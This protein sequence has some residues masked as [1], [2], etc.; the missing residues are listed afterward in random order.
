MASVCPRRPH[1]GKCGLTTLCW[2]KSFGP[3]GINSPPEGGVQG[4]QAVPAAPMALPGVGRHA[5]RPPGLRPLARVR[6]PGPCCLCHPAGRASGH[7]CAR[8]PGW[9]TRSVVHAG[10]PAP[11]FP[12]GFSF[13]KGGPCKARRG[14]PGGVPPGAVERWATRV[15]AVG[16][17][18]STRSVVP[19]VHGPQ[20]CPR[21]SGP[22]GAAPAPHG[23]RP[24][25]ALR[26]QKRS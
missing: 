21:R 24:P 13:S 8:W 23:S 2:A 7:G 25:Q 17:Q 6:A 4:P 20:R 11:L 14:V 1:F 5:P 26:P 22:Q 15:R 18:G 16:G 3:A 19:A 12:L 9:S 10:R